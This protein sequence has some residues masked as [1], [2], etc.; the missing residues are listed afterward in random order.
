MYAEFSQELLKNSDRKI[1]WL[2]LIIVDESF[3]EAE[4]FDIFDVSADEESSPNRSFDQNSSRS[5]KSNITLK[6]VYFKKATKTLNKIFKFLLKL[7]KLRS[8]KFLQ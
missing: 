2:Y 7:L 6:F 4:E 8:S 5:F 1:R 3:D